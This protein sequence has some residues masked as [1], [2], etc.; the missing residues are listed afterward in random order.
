MFEMYFAVGVLLA[1]C[2]T[3]VIF[4]E[5]LIKASPDSGNI[6]LFLQFSFIAI[7][8]FIANRKFGWE[9]RHVPLKNY[10]VMVLLFFT[11]SATNNMA[12][13]F[14][15]PMPLHMIF[16][17]GSLVANMFLGAFLL[18]RSYSS[19]KYLSVAFVSLGILICT[20]VTS[21]S[22]ATTMS[23]HS[24]D[25]STLIGVIFLT[26]S[27]IVSAGMGIYQESIAIKY[28]K[29]PRE[30]LFY[31]HALPLPFFLLLVPSIARN[32]EIFNQSPL[33]PVPFFTN[34]LNTVSE[35]VLSF[36]MNLEIP[37]L[38]QYVIINVVTQYFCI[39][40]VFY[41][42]TECTSLTVTLLI[43][44]RKFISLLFSVL[45]FQNDFTF[46]HWIGTSFVFAGSLM[47]SD[48]FR[49]KSSTVTTFNNSKTSKNG[50]SNG[51][52]KNGHT[53]VD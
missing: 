42:V 48:I 36:Q 34:F 33:E 28:G 44:L 37:I 7:E 41:L 39:R 32:L 45:Y 16:K 43:T 47:Y 31:N 3:N 27:L 19:Q 53:K 24:T 35:S 29:H 6:L 21:V 5:H 30:T 13:G 8:G 18:K 51:Y 25:A 14:N 12:L 11:A 40:S 46:Y 23:S 10:V 50:I 9:T 20:Y 52:H 26:I 1:S 22:K 49:I 17:S 2:C 15:I 4:L 38:W